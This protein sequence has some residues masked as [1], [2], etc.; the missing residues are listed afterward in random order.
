MIDVNKSNIL[1]LEEELIKKHSELYTAGIEMAGAKTMHDSLER[2]RKSVRANAMPQEGSQGTK[3]AEAEKSDAYKKHLT[4][5][6]AAQLNYLK[7]EVKYESLKSYID[8]LRTIISN[9]RTM[10]QRGIEDTKW[11]LKKY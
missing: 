4:A 7:A 1:Q 11:T 10:L 3:E 2:V 5:L 9:R 8:S 6:D